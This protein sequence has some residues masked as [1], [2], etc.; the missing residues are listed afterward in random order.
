[1]VVEQYYI[2]SGNTSSTKPLGSPQSNE[3]WN[4]SS[5][6]KVSPNTEYTITVPS[7]LS[8]NNSGMCFY[9]SNTVESAISAVSTATQGGATYT[10]TTPSNCNYIRFSWKNDN[11]NDCKLYKSGNSATCQNLLGAGTYKDVQSIL[12]GSITRNIGVLIFDGTESWSY[13]DLYHRFYTNMNISEAPIINPNG[14]RSIPAFCTHFKILTNGEAIAE[15]TA[16]QGYII[17]ASINVTGT[18]YFHSDLTSTSAFKSWLATQ[19]ANG[20][21]IIVVYPKYAA[22]SESTTTQT[23]TLQE[24]TNVIEV[25][26][27]SVSTLPLEVSYKA[28]VTVTVTEVEN[29]NLDNSVTVTIGG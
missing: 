25:T 1:M 20:T 10:F 9:S 4:C 11:G 14:T 6:I 7:Y 16:G 28:G 5:Y 17:R 29:A 26:Q 23:L 19:Y 24:G 15:V 2:R 13:E 18:L 21:P 8:S 12:D 27:A 3:V 22:T